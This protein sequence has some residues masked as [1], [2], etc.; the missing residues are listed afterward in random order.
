MIERKGDRHTVHKRIGGET[1]RRWY[2]T[3][4]VL[5]ALAPDT[6]QPHSTFFLPNS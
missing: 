1:Q 5:D 4:Y 3:L 2:M 6:V